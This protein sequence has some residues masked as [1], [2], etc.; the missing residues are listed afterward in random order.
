MDL[1]RS[2]SSWLEPSSPTANMGAARQYLASTEA[3][4]LRL[5]D[6]PLLL[7]DFSRQVH[8]V[9]APGILRGGDGPWTSNTLFSRADIDTILSRSSMGGNGAAG[10]FVHIDADALRLGD[11][12]ELQMA[13]RLNL[14]R[15]S[16]TY[17]QMCA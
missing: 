14:E 12:H 2:S 16:N 5:A 6:L 11:V 1:G 8:A 10:K 4:Q 17:S 13:Y 9:D 7:S 15:V 3:G